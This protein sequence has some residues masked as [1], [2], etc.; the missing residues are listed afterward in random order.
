MVQGGADA[1]SGR[2]GDGALLGTRLVRL[3]SYFTIQSNLLVLAT[4]LL[5]AVRPRRTGGL[6]RAVRL[7]ALLGITVTGLVFATVL[8][9]NLHLTGPAL[10]CTVAFHYVSPPATLLGW[11][12]VEERSPF[13]KGDLAWSLLWPTAWI[14]YTLAHGA[15]TG[16]YPYP[17]LDVVALGYPAALRN[18]AVV[19]AGA[20]LIAA[21][22][23]WVSRLR[24]RAPDPG[25]AG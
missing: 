15:A 6:W 21:L 7:D 3:F 5:L 8:A 23:V 11:L 17:F 19:V 18:L 13:T 4:S 16:W 1:N 12:L 24:G 2:A 14:D 10:A 9:P 22:L 20:L 25:A